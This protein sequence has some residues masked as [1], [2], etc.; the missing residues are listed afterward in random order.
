[1]CSLLSLS[2]EKIVSR[3]LLQC[4]SYWLFLNTEWLLN[5]PPSATRGGFFSRFSPF[6]VASDSSAGPEQSP[7]NRT[8]SMVDVKPNTYSGTCLALYIY[9]MYMIMQCMDKHIVVLFCTA[10]YLKRHIRE[11]H[12]SLPRVW[13][14]ITWKTPVRAQYILN[15]PRTRM[16]IPPVPILPRP[17]TVCI[18]VSRSFNASLVNVHSV[19]PRHCLLRL[20][21]AL[22]RGAFALF[23]CWHRVSPASIISVFAYTRTRNI[24]R[25]WVAYRYRCRVQ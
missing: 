9:S 12:Q 17:L 21:E 2:Y 23:A 6:S 15:F 13:V 25:V 5:E 22:D 24:G 4:H 10:L 8:S 16:H 14:R 1:M 19:N 20:I 18:R 11:Q 3:C 7:R